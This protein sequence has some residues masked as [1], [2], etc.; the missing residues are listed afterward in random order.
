[1]GAALTYIKQRRTAATHN[2]TGKWRQ[3]AT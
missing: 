3:N 2:G 1:V